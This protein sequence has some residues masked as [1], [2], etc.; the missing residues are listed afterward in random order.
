VSR[1]WVYRLVTVSW[2]FEQLIGCV[3]HFGFGGFVEL[4]FVRWCERLFELLRE[5]V[6]YLSWCRDKLLVDLE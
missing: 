5:C 1:C 4:W 2:R 3:L 6:G